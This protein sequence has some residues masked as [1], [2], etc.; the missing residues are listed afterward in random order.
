MKKLVK[1]WIKQLFL[2]IFAEEFNKLNASYSKV[3]EEVF[4]CEA[5]R[6]KFKKLLDGIDVS[7]DVHEYD[8][9]Y[10]PSWAVVSLQGKNTDYIKFIELGNSDIRDIANFL[11]SYERD[12]NIKT[13]ASPHASKFLRI[14][15]RR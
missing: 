8:Y 3:N 9:K 6:L 4:N 1:G 10:S 7:V 15:R 12:A 13:D 14:G 11:R 5:Q 2:W